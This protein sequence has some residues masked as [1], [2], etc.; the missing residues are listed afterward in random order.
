MSSSVNSLAGALAATILSGGY[1]YRR[2]DWCTEH[3]EQHTARTRDEW[4]IALY[5]YR[6]KGTPQPFPVICSHGMAGTHLIYDLHPDYSLARYLANRG[7]DT[8][9]VDLRGRGDSWPDAGASRKLQWCFDDFV[10]H[11]MP[12]ATA[13]VCETT[14]AD[15]AF[16]L[17]MEMSGQ[18]L[19]AASILGKVPQIRGAV[20]FGSPVL[21]PNHAQVPGVN[22]AP[23]ASWRGRV[24]FRTQ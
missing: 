8:W 10:E 2:F 24:P 3:D 9:L 1:W 21:T 18:V 15:Q 11:D 22:A 20:T 12:A 7:F 4:N 6:P 5:R 13:L 19:Y 23:Q 16:W 14:G 17:G